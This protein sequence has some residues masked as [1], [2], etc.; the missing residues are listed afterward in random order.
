MQE[1]RRTFH[2]FAT[3]SSAN[4]NQT[5]DQRTILHK[6]QISIRDDL[7]AG[8]H[9]ERIADRPK[10]CPVSEWPFR[11]FST[12]HNIYYVKS[13][14]PIPDSGYTC[15]PFMLCRLQNMS[16]PIVNNFSITSTEGNVFGHRPR[17]ITS[18]RCRL[19]KEAVY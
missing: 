16:I 19:E 4:S 2:R 10:I 11:P 8:K 7:R 6:K 14:A 9:Q 15:Y 17:K 5:Q 18:K 13:S 12:S 3:I 1:K